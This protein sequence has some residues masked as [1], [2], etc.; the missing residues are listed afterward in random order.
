MIGCRFYWDVSL[1]DRGK[2]ESLVLILG[3]PVYIFTKHGGY[4]PGIK[5]KHIPRV[6]NAK[7]SDQEQL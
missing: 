4:S 6:I 7:L 3:F 5:T 1:E 2:G